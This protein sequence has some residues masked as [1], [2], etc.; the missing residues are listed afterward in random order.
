[1]ATTLVLS[2]GNASKLREI[3][4]ILRD[5][6]LDVASLT[7]F[8]AIDEPIE[9]GETFGDN[10]RIKAMYY[11]RATGQWCLA[12]DSGLHVDALNGEPGVHSARYAQDDF[13]PGADRQMRDAANNARLLREL[14]G[15]EEM[16]RSARFICHLAL[17]DGAGVLLEAR[18][19]VEG[20]ILNQP[21]GNNG[22]GYDPLFFL[23]ELDMTAAELT[24]NEKNR[25]SHR[26][27]AVRDFAQQLRRLLASS[28]T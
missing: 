23:P 7:D 4:Q 13:P 25:I 5:L 22:F 9:D 24:A 10:A 21:R 20:I 8:P 12:D 19:S 16:Q 28:A 18:G 17:A 2:T 11:A 15:V 14:V 6:P 26:G 27:K 3:E 1:M